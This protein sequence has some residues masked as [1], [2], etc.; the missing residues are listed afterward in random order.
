M[1]GVKM[2]SRKKIVLIEWLYVLVLMVIFVLSGPVFTEAG[3]LRVA[4]DVSS[5]YAPGF[6]LIGVVPAVVLRGLSLLC[7]GINWWMAFSV[8]TLAVPIFILIDTISVIVDERISAVVAVLFGFAVYK[9]VLVEEI[10]YTQNVAL[11][12]AVGFALMLRWLM[13]LE[14]DEPKSESDGSD[15]SRSGSRS[16]GIW[17]LILGAF[18]I[19]TAGSLRWKAL[20]M[21]LPFA[22]MIAGWRVVLNVIGHIKKQ[23]KDGGKGFGLTYRHEILVVALMIALVFGS[24]A[25]HKVYEK[26]NPYYAEYV[27]ANELRRDIYDYPERYPIWEDAQKE[28]QA[29]G[30]EHS[31]YAMVFQSYTV[32]MNQFSAEKLRVMKEFRQK[33]PYTFMDSF[34]VLKGHDMMW[35]ALAAMGVVVV[36][37]AFAGRKS[38]L[39]SSAVSGRG[40]VAT[41]ALVA[42]IAAV[43]ACV[44]A[45]AILGRNGWRVM[46]GI[47]FMSAVSFLFMASEKFLDLE[48]RDYPFARE[49]ANDIN[50]GITKVLSVALVTVVS[51][52][53]I[54][55]DI[56]FIAPQ[57]G[58]TN[59][60]G[61]RFID[62]LDFNENTAYLMCDDPYYHK[63]YGVWKGK[64]PTCCDNVFT[65]GGGFGLGRLS[66]MERL[67]INDIVPDMLNKSNIY[68]TYDDVW[69]AYLLDYYD[70]NISV[71]IVD[72]F[73]DKNF[74]RYVA[75]KAAG[76][77][78][79]GVTAEDMTMKLVHSDSYNGYTMWTID[80]KLTGDDEIIG[81]V[82]E[83][84]VNVV[85]T[86]TGDI[87]TYPL[88]YDAGN[89]RLT[90]QCFYYGDW[91]F[92]DTVRFIMGVIDGE[93]VN[94]V[95]VSGAPVFEE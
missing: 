17:M 67:G 31:W 94:L 11:L 4:D 77:E 90:G 45:F 28:Y 95:D 38:K 73:E 20:V 24:A 27:A 58:I 57:T 41:L 10:C 92:G 21:C 32:D 75:P 74:I 54:I 16:R 86:T 49:K 50:T 65:C 8:V 85:N 34:R 55:K 70:S 69:H 29:A 81:S 76:G 9:G 33:S 87:H 36:G 14:N 93:C 83:Y 2:L 91:S 12:A 13:A 80:C 63:S 52:F 84:Y 35:L 43:L 71:G 62:Y 53:L 46:V 30:I 42:N 59:E 23:G 15:G 78:I 88:I 3:D 37:A 1:C 56:T 22:V 6:F 66:D 72:T 7:P 25:I 64:D 40:I 39:G 68:T 5:T 79:P 82:S 18:L 89:N 47:V 48:C 60:A 51:L 44:Y 61:A 26:I 19:L